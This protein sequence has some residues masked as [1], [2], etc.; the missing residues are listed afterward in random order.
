M[1]V[2]SVKEAPQCAKVRLMATPGPKKG[3]RLSIE[4][5]PW[6]ERA[7][8]CQLADAVQLRVPG[9][10]PGETARVEVTARSKGGPVGWARLVA[11]EDPGPHGEARRDAP[12][13]IHETCGGCGLQ[14]VREEKR[15][16]LLV[17]SQAASL[18]STLAETLAPPDQWIRSAGFAWR[19]K[20]VLLPALE[21]GRLS[22]GG[23]GRG[24]HD[25]VDQP[26]CEVLA[27]RLREA[28]AALLPLI[29]P[30]S[31]RG[32]LPAPPG[33]EGA[34]GLRSLVLRGN[35]SGGVLVT[36]VVRSQED[37]QGLSPIL[38]EAVADEH[39]DGAFIQ[40]LA[41]SSDA[42]HG[43]DEPTL[44]AGIGQLDESVAGVTLP[45]L[46]LAFFQVNPTVLEGIILRL[47]TLSEGAGVLMDAY[48]GVGALGIAVAAGLDP[49]PELVG[50]DLV[51]SAVSAAAG[52]AEHHGLTARYVTGTPKDL[53]GESASIV[54]V[55]P[56]RKGCSAAELN[57]LLSGSPQR[58]LYVSCSSKSLARDAQR[59]LD[60]GYTATGLWPAD[61]LPQT[62]HLE[63]VAAFD[64]TP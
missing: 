41:S 48:C 13:S 28:R 1:L 63:W 64:L 50:C 55:D 62:A 16:E 3:E 56:P 35:R 24:T 26:D 44:V 45:V 61:M 43:R 42:V 27:P 33:E 46:P 14:Y 19:H 57:A 18:P 59:L 22:L 53:V 36:A 2:G 32:L 51:A 31:V 10:I 7:E 34:R 37:V 39:I 30:A 17:A 40:I 49:S 60:A 15:L 21:R 23:F 9:L 54:L 20:T 52:C 4:A 29:Q 58:V 47:R 6:N 25:V 11:V 8:T 12:C 38:E 5:G